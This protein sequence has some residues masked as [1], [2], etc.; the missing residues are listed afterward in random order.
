MRLD[1]FY[2][3]LIRPEALKRDQLIT[4]KNQVAGHAGFF[5]LQGN[6]NLCLK[7]FNT[8]CVRGRREHLFYQL[9]EYFKR[10]KQ[11]VSDDS[12]SSST[13]GNRDS[14]NK[15][16]ERTATTLYYKHFTLLTYPSPATKCNCIIDEAL[17]KLL[18]SFVANFYHVKH[19]SGEST[20]NDD[21]V[22]GYQA[23]NQF[24]NSV[25]SEQL[26]CPCYGRNP[27]KKSSCSR[28]YDKIDFLCLE[29]LT[30]HCREP[31]IIDIKIGQI[32]YDPMAIKEKV[33]EQSSKYRR[34]RE[35]GFRILGMKLGSKS[36]G[37]DFG[38]T[39]E[40]SEQVFEALDSFF[41]P[42]N[43]C[44]YKSSV[45]GQIL[46]RLQSLL[47]WFETVNANQL[48]FFSSSLLIVYDS[49][50][51]N[52]T[53]RPTSIIQ[54]ELAE[55]VRVSM[56]DFAHVFHVHDATSSDSHENTTS[57]SKDDNYIF[58]LKKLEQF[59][60]RL[61]QHHQSPPHPLQV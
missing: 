20:D 25:Y 37:K 27:K 41:V 26:T 56:I 8:K 58:G 59:F 40:T 4:N 30:A 14:E 48:K 5:S 18:S 24:L 3:Q 28:D 15:L 10:N 57:D 17:F 19:L 21:F 54:E 11:T 47:I 49:F 50:I 33:L 35:F 44:Y 51:E 13:S 36:R 52:E 31:C 1:Q 60:V 55:S 39:L 29:D 43:E 6:S 9:V 7:P 16:N 38:K 12:H 42:L 46:N 53:Q 23:H 22:I 2:K 32:T 61:N 45:I 34:L